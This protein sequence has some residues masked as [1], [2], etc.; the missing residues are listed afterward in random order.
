IV[1]EACSQFGAVG[2][3][4]A[5]VADALGGLDVA[6]R[7][8]ERLVPDV[9]RLLFAKTPH[10]PHLYR[11]PWSIGRNANSSVMIVA[12]ARSAGALG[13]DGLELGLLLV[14]ERAQEIVQRRRNLPDGVQHGVD[15]GLGGRKPVRWVQ[16]L[17][18]L[19][20]EI[21][22]VAGERA[23]ALEHAELIAL[24]VAE[25][26]PRLDLFRRPG[27]GIRRRAALRERN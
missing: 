16:V 18:G 8:V 1:G 26:Q 2:G 21:H 17:V 11:R 14:A 9:P 22:G 12:S 19:A 4:A 20:V 27:Q 7:T 10:T 6:E 23:R 15:P 24:V 25:M 5:D 13:P 3:G